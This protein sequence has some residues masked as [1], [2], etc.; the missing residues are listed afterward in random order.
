MVGLLGVL[1]AGGAYV[2]LDP[3]YPEERLRYMLEDSEA[4]VLLTQSHLREQFAAEAE[5]KV[6]VV[7]LSEGAREWEGEPGTNPDGR[8][9]GLKARHLA[10]VIYTSGSTGAAEGGDGGTSERGAAGEG[11]GV[12]EVWERGAGVADGAGV[13]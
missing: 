2:P 1:K 5:G 11:S 3:G 6:A 10:Y 12:R 7:D 13:V 4:K 8:G 9:I